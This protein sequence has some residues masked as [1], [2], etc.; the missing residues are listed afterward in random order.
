M[1]VFREPQYGDVYPDVIAGAAKELTLQGLPDQFG[2]RLS[3]IEDAGIRAFC[4][5]HWLLLITSS[6]AL[7][8]TGQPCP[9]YRRAIHLQHHPHYYHFANPTN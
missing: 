5:R 6:L 7:L 8:I 1:Q 2:F 3:S 4:G 9:S